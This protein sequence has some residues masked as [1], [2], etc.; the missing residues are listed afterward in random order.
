MFTLEMY[1]KTF[2]AEEVPKLLFDCFPSPFIMNVDSFSRLTIIL[3][4]KTQSRG[5]ETGGRAGHKLRLTKLLFV[6]FFFSISA[7]CSLARFLCGIVAQ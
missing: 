2:I 1:L 6:H 5:V 4:Y 3:T 7:W